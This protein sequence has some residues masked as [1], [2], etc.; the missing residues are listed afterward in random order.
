M[1]E[2]SWNSE[3]SLLDTDDMSHLVYKLKRLKTEVKGWVKK[4]KLLK[5]NELSEIDLEI[6]S[7]FTSWPSRIL[8]E[9]RMALFASLKG[10]KEKFLAH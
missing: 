3:Y 9:A 2:A 10:C 8:S 5:D 7:L 1:V 6:Q 4:Q